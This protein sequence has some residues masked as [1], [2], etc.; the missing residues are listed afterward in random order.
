LSLRGGGADAAISRR[1]WIVVAF[2]LA[3]LETQ[4]EMML[5]ELAS[6]IG[7]SV[8]AVERAAARVVAPEAAWA[9]VVNADD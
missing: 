1:R 4:P 6:A 2:G 8:S 5:A 9:W 7:K 3:M